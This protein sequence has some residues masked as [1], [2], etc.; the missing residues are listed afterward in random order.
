M[1]DSPEPPS[2]RITFTLPLLSNAK[3]VAFV[4]SGVSRSEALA[5]VLEEP[6]LELPASRIVAAGAPNVYFADQAAVAETT[7]PQ[8]SFPT[9]EPERRPEEEK[10]ISAS[11]IVVPVGSSSSTHGRLA[12]DLDTPRDQQPKIVLHPDP[13]V[14]SFPDETGVSEAL[15]QFILEA[16]EQSVRRRG[17]FTIA[18]SGGSVPALLSSGILE[19]DSVD[20]EHW[21]IFFVDERLVPPTHPDSNF[22]AY[23]KALFSKVPQLGEGQVHA[24]S[25]PD[26]GTPRDG[27]VAESVAREYELDVIAALAHADDQKAP[28]FDLVVLDLGRDG[29]T[30]ALFP[31]HPLIGE[32]DWCVM[33][34]VGWPFPM[35][36]DS[37]A[38]RWV[39]SLTDSPEPPAARVTMS[40]TMINAAR[41]V[42]FVCTGESKS[43]ALATVLDEPECGLP[44][45]LVKLP[46]RPVVWFVDDAAASLTKAPRASFWEEDEGEA[47]K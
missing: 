28:S 31:G 18:L 30:A 1:T 20:W 7:F 5:A 40:L 4:V 16:E 23:V 17:T 34:R 41:R 13:I 43:E 33:T 9:P 39:A 25:M 38:R 2:A 11:E 3:H 37:P 24:I 10:V 44:A 32:H 36:I 19:S 27:P 8:S 45:S 47:A 14:F 15:A 6:E 42:A 26:E 21:Q 22:R 35:L 12:C 46:Y 29:H